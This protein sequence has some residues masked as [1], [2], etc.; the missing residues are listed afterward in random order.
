VLHERDAVLHELLHARAAER[1][2]AHERLP[3]VHAEVEAVVHAHGRAREHERLDGRRRAQ[4]ADLRRA[5]DDVAVDLRLRARVAPVVQVLVQ[6]AQRRVVRRQ[7]RHE[8]GEALRRPLHRECGLVAAGEQH[9]PG[10]RRARGA[11]K[12]GGST[13]CCFAYFLLPMSTTL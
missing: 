10:G 3:H 11:Q 2:A 9:V 6:R 1:A 7:R 12:G 5:R 13:P 8:R 4:P